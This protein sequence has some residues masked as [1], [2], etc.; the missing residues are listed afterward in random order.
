MNLPRKKQQGIFI[1]KSVNAGFKKPDNSAHGILEDDRRPLTGVHGW[2]V[3][4]LSWVV[5]WVSEHINSNYFNL[6]RQPTSPYLPVRKLFSEFTTNNLFRKLFL[7]K[8][9]SLILIWFFQCVKLF[10]VKNLAI[11]HPHRFWLHKVLLMIYCFMR[12]RAQR[13]N[14]LTAENYNSSHFLRNKLI[15]GHD[16]ETIKRDF[17]SV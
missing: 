9:F 17:V 13:F 6:F 5:A 12:K 8:I 15:S 16:F 11:H 3:E 7:K 10:F 1:Y 2:I 4:A 14:R